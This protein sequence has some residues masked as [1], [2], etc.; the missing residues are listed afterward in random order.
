[1]EKY[2]LEKDIN[3]FFVAASSFPSGIKAAHEKLHAL[4]GDT[5]GRRFFG[6]SSGSANGS[7]S[8]KAAVEAIHPGEA[9]TLHCETFIIRKGTYIS[10]T[11]KDWKK[12]E[13]IVAKTFQQLLSY[14]GLDQNG[15]CLEMY[16]NN[17]DMICLV[18]L[19]NDQQ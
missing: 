10:E 1:M 6:I 19:A 15:Y 8:Y 17:E 4:L 16:P 9:A 11:I 18:T 12:D 3:T 13:S 14:P 7:I 5:T 2:I